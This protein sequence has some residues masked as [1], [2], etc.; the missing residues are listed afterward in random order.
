MIHNFTPNDLVRFIYRE[1][2]SVEDAAIREWLTDDS[3]AFSVFQEM[4]D[5][6]RSLDIK[7][8]EPSET[9]INILLEF[10]KLS[11]H[12]ESHA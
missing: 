1:T 12:E 10:S 9:S 2:T 7:E 3:S 8:K 6:V 11:A 4:S 5:T